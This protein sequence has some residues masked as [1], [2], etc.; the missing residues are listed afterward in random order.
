MFTH[1]HVFTFQETLANISAIATDFNC[2]SSAYFQGNKVL[3]DKSVIVKILI[4][5]GAFILKI[6]TRDLDRISKT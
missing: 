2:H 1:R 3:G 5:N 4:K 6:Q